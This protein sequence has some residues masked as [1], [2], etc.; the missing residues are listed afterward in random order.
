MKDAIRFF[1]TVFFLL[2]LLAGAWFGLIQYASSRD[3][4]TY[5]TDLVKQ[6]LENQVSAFSQRQFLQLKYDQGKWVVDNQP[7]ELGLSGFLDKNPNDLI[8]LNLRLNATAQAKKLKQ[9]LSAKDRWKRV[10][11]LSDSDGT[12]EDLR[13]LGPR[14][15]FSNGEVFMTRFLTMASLGLQGLLD[16]TGDVFFI[17]LNHFEPVSQFSKLIDEARR[18]NK[19][20]ILGPVEK[21]I[22]GLLPHAWILKPPPL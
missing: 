21:P 19:F 11:V 22:P 16:V 9:V 18:Q 12:L 1:Y 17:N 10:I 13:A 15:T 8:L 4:P 2:I 7:T 14:W 20:V 3:K 5:Q 6:L